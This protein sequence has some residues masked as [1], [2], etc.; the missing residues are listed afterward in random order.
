MPSPFPGMDPFLEDPGILPDLHLSMI[1]YLAEALH[2]KLPALHYAAIRS[3]TWIGPILPSSETV[4]AL[5]RRRH[6]NRREPAPEARTATEPPAKP[7]VIEVQEHE[8]RESYL[9]ILRREDAKDRL[10]TTIELLSPSN[11][12]PHDRG[13]KLYLRKQRDVLCSKANLVEIDLLRDGRHTTAVPRECVLLHAGRF[14]YHVCI[15]RFG[16]PRQYVVYPISLRERLPTVEI[17]LLKGDGNVTV[18]LQALL[19]HCY[20]VGRYDVQARYD[21]YRPQ[22]PLRPEDAKWV[23][24]LLREKGLVP[25]G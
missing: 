5:L 13:R 14:D 9:E 25:R 18:D 23:A 21:K 10:V 16:K 12:T 17:P 2:P 1:V 3:R 8:F 22:P 20:E 15:R 11:K 24:Q 19:D 4:A 6:R 7:V